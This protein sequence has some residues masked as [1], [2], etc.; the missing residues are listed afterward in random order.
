MLLFVLACLAGCGS[1]EPEGPVDDKGK[2]I[3]I[4]PAGE[5]WLLIQNISPKLDST[6]I[7]TRPTF[8]ITFNQYIDEES[9]LSYNVASIDTGGQR[10]FGRAQYIMTRNLIRWTP[11][12]ALRPDFEY[13]FKIILGGVRSI[14]EAP[15]WPEK[16]KAFFITR[17]EPQED[18]WD[19]DMRSRTWSDVEAIFDKHCNRCHGDAQ[20]GLPELTWAVLTQ[21]QSTQLPRPLVRPYSPSNSYLMHKILPDYPDRLNTVQPPPW[22]EDSQTLTEAEIWTIEKWIK[23]GAPGPT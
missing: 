4:P 9:Y 19:L 13:E 17:D 2:P 18:D 23:D 11:Y 7:S 21:T 14:S 15:L 6:E 10:N 16:P 8:E 3:P 5:Q 22:D 20:W 1:I 12:R